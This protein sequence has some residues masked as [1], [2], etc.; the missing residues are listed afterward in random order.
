VC[1]RYLAGAFDT[2]DLG[3]PFTAYGWL[4]SLTAVVRVIGA[5]ATGASRLGRPPT[6][7][8]SPAGVSTPTNESPTFLFGASASPDSP[9]GGT[10]LPTPQLFGREKAHKPGSTLSARKGTQRRHKKDTS[11]KPSMPTTESASAWSMF[12]A[13]LGTFSP[14]VGRHAAASGNDPSDIEMEQASPEEQEYPSTSTGMRSVLW[15]LFL[16]LR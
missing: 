5:L 7:S 6:Q 10:N 12:S 4:A 1:R 8:E 14:V 13:S 9:H 16:T 11:A 3:E 15:T 2:Y